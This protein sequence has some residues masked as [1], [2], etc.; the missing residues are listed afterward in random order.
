MQWWKGI[1]HSQTRLFNGSF[2][3]LRKKPGEHGDDVGVPRPT[4]VALP[5]VERHG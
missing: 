4:T 3:E 2:E 1:E 5:N